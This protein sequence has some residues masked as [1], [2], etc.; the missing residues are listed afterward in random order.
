MAHSLYVQTVCHHKVWE[1]LLAVGLPYQYFAD[2]NF[3]NGAATTAAKAGLED[4][5][6][7]T[8]GR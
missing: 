1:A 6:I 5:T 8:L 2:H 3:C 4:S 7:C